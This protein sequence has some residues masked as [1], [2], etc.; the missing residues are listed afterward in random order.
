MR[1]VHL[2]HRIDCLAFALEEETHLNVDTAVLA[3]LGLGP[4]PWLS[5]LK[6]AVRAERPD[7]LCIRAEWRQDGR[8]H[9]RAFGL[10]ELRE[11]LVKHTPGHKIA[12]VVDTLYSADNAAR[13]AGLAH[14][15]DVLFCESPFVHAD[16]ETGDSALPP[17][18]A[19]GR[20]AGTGGPGQETGR[21]SLFAPLLGSGRGL[22]PGSP[23]D[24]RGSSGGALMT[25]APS[26]P[27]A[28]LDPN[29]MTV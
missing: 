22:V 10:G 21:L 17:D 23:R 7:D 9:E 13:I 16:H 14:R 29:S 15:A 28:V 3:E 2:D 27:S 4:G 19:P 26:A 8:R 25:G 18:R 5:E 20:S 11:R 6:R 24:V 12:Y 1:T